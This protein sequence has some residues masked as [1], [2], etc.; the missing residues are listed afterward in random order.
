MLKCGLLAHPFGAVYLGDCPPRE[1]GKSRNLRRASSED[2]EEGDIFDD[3]SEGEA[4]FGCVGPAKVRV[5]TWEA[6]DNVL[7]Q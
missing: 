3:K 6:L 5:M 2:E 4:F 1:M 7:P